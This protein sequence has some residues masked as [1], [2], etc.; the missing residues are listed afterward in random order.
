MTTHF[1]KGR[2]SPEL[3]HNQAS[4]PAQLR[5]LSVGQLANDHHWRCRSIILNGPDMYAVFQYMF[6]RFQNIQHRQRNIN[7]LVTV[8]IVNNKYS[9]YPFAVIDY[10]QPVSTS[11]TMMKHQSYPC[12]AVTWLWCHTCRPT[13]LVPH[14][15]L[16]QAGSIPAGMPSWACD[17]WAQAPVIGSSKNDGNNEP[18]LTRTLINHQW[19]YKG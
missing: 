19:L 8:M 6:H 1:R 12:Y 17:L 4:Q 7:Q 13:G 3:T 18:L 14:A 2:G 9:N 10:H 5:W 15:A 11:T 16:A